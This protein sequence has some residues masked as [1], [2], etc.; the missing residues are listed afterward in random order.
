M[1]HNSAAPP[2]VNHWPSLISWTGQGQIPLMHQIHLHL[3]ITDN[4]LTVPVLPHSADGKSPKYAGERR[5]LC[6][7]N[8]HIFPC[9]HPYWEILKEIFENEEFIRSDFPLCPF[10]LL[11]LE[12]LSQSVLENC[13][14]DILT[15]LF[16]GKS[17]YSK[18]VT[19]WLT[20]S[21][22]LLSPVT[23]SAFMPEPFARS[24]SVKF[25]T[26]WTP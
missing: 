3:I 23:M 6:E 4:P 7:T 14:T 11:V 22:K 20:F 18:N 12:A 15:F 26:L 5:K 25:G 17:F 24:P 8:Q 2:I 19:S 10:S 1:V 16:V 21:V 13:T 9:Y